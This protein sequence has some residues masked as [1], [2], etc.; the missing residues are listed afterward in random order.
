MTSRTRASRRT[1]RTVPGQAP[2]A[3]SRGR[4]PL[5]LLA[6]RMTL[7][8]AAAALAFTAAWRE[9]RQFGM[10]SDGASIA[11]QAWQVL[12]GNPLLRGWHVAD[13]SFYTT[14][15]PVYMAVEAV[16]GLR[17]DVAAISEA[18]NYTLTL[19]CGALVAKGQAV[20]REGLARALLAAGIMLA[21]TLAAASWLLNDADHAATALW[22][23]LALLVV[24]RAG[25]RWYVPV[26]VTLVL[27]WAIIGDPLVEVIGA[28][29][30]ALAGIARAYAG[31]SRDGRPAGGRPPGDGLAREGSRAAGLLR[32]R[33]FELSL[34]MAGI[35]SA[36]LGTAVTHAIT[37]AGGWALTTTGQRFVQVKVLPSNLAVE[38]EDFLGLY[39]ADFFGQKVNGGITPV[40]IH[41]AGA[42]V[43]AAGIW[44]AIRRFA[45]S[46]ERGGDLV[47]D[48]LLLGIVG[49][50]GAYLLLYA[51]T[52]H[53]IREVAPV[54]ALGAVLAG[55]ALGGPIARRRLEPV[56][57]I[58]IACY[59]LT[60]GP[61][62]T[63]HAE[64]PA[65]LALTRWLERHHLSNGLSGYW[66]AN[67]V[68]F[69]SGD[70][71]TMRSVKGG[72]DGRPV[73]NPWESDISELNPAVNSA[74]FLVLAHGA[75]AAS[76][77]VTEAGAVAE[78]GKPGKVYHVH[79]YTVL[80]WRENVLVPL[81]SKHAGQHR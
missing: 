17:F 16:R 12:H 30:L 7:W 46:R 74:D 60:M 67:S 58:G 3:G 11:L 33:W 52:P 57:A 13:V 56:L 23:L 59:L 65:N 55:R 68:T 51:A 47:A 81:T 80:M 22:V 19:A 69:D 43:V 38:L 26:V 10:Q 27:A 20:G 28:A 36:V 45:R 1:E 71:V 37:S 14:E 25:R 4:R 29:P 5:V 34:A 2:E 64:P 73:V 35:M 24:D 40:V 6:V 21:P 49:N 48:V 15:L 42:I 76:P 78:F 66:Q 32:A 8:A 63:G 44:T 41:L 53:Q 72:A 75:A 70:R 61:A 79:G 62:V 9:A 39:S 18:I 77:P 50:L 31:L 54:F